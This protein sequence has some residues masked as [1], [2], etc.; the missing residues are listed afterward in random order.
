MGEVVVADK[1]RGSTIY[2]TL[3]THTHIYNTHIIYINM[4]YFWRNSGDWIAHSEARVIAS[5]SNKMCVIRIHIYEEE[6]EGK[7]H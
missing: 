5:N 7:M 6:E 4:L 2:A 3:H 1:V